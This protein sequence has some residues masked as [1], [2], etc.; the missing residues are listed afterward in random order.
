MLKNI[1]NIYKIYKISKICLKMLLEKNVIE[2]NYRDKY[3]LL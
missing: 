1:S 3:M 2:K